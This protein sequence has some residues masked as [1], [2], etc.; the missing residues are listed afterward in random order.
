MKDTISI[1][2][3]ISTILVSWLIP[4]NKPVENYNE[5]T[6]TCSNQNIEYV[7]TTPMLQKSE[8]VEVIQYKTNVKEEYSEDIKLIALV[9]IAEA[10]GES[11]EGKRLVIDTILNRVDS[12]YFPDTVYDVIYQPNQ[13]TSMWNGRVD[14]CKSTDEVCALVA[15]ELELRT[16]TSVIFFTAGQYSEYGTPMYNVGNH[17]FSSY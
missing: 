5:N 4:D 8:P 7:D 2:F 16:N 11:E 3:V 15:E 14:R 10:E 13:F 9:V 17:Y 6:V 1:L 12:E